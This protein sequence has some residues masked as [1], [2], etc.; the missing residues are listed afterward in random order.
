LE[1]I[2]RRGSTSDLSNQRC[3]IAR[4]PKWSISFSPAEADQSGEAFVNN[5]LIPAICRKAG[6]PERDARGVITSHRARATIA[7]QLFNSKE[8]LSL[9]ELQA[10]LGHS[11]P[12]STQHYARIKPTRLAK[13]DPNADYFA[14]NMRSIEVL[15]D[16]DAII[17]GV[18]SAGEAWRFH[19]LGHGYCTYEFSI[20]ARTGWRAPSAASTGRRAQ[21]RLKSSRRK[22]TCCISSRTFP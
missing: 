15:I 21:A 20:S 14:R 22:R 3:S 6:V 9:F 5:T 13:A 11:S 19:D 12:Q 7:T 8:P 18:A 10:W 4:R 2:S 1:K 16:R 17:S